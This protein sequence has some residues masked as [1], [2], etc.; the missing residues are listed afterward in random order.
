MTC[1]STACS[2]GRS[3]AG[4][5]SALL[6]RSN[7]ALRERLCPGSAGEAGLAVTAACCTS[8]DSQAKFLSL[9]VT[10]VRCRRSDDPTTPPGL[11]RR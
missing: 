1:P 11:G 7:L 3:C 10:A 5:D 4:Q 2:W 6:V 8:K 9:A